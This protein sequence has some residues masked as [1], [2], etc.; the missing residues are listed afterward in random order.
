MPTENAVEQCCL[1]MGVGGREWKE[2]VAATRSEDVAFSGFFHIIELST[3]AAGKK[4]R[5]RGCAR[6]VRAGMLARTPRLSSTHQPSSSIKERCVV[7]T[8]LL[9]LFPL[10]VADADDDERGNGSLGGFLPPPLKV[11]S[12]VNIFNTPCPQSCCCCCTAC[13][14]R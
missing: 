12:F 7:C 9:Y 6:G 13:G 5:H 2:R 11:K 1:P 8:V 14:S 3:A 4:M 10:K